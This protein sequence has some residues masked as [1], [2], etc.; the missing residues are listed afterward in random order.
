[1]S[2][3]WRK[4]LQVRPLVR[5]FIW[6]RIGDGAKAY[7]W[8]DN[9]CFIGPLAEFITNRDIYIAGFW[10]YVKVRDIIAND[11]WGWP[12][13]WSVKYPMLVNSNVPQ[14][15]TYAD[16]IYWKY[17]NNLETTFSVYKAWH[18][19]RPRSIVMDWFHVVWFS[20]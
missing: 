15:A 3:G 1:M 16:R 7:A 8:F 9:W 20:H 18:C 19:I 10:L 12:N 5:P 6:F 14:L 13:E 2:W 11:S 4:I 17:H